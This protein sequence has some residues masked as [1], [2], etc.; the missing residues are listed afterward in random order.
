MYIT[1]G[2]RSLS[3]R[4]FK[5]FCTEYFFTFDCIHDSSG[6]PRALQMPFICERPHL[7][8]NERR[9]SDRADRQEMAVSY[10]LFIDPEGTRLPSVRQE[11]LSPLPVCFSA[12]IAE[13]MMVLVPG[14]PVYLKIY[15]GAAA[16]GLFNCA[17]L[18]PLLGDEYS[19]KADTVIKA[20]SAAIVIL[21][22]SE[23]KS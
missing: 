3:I 10:G 9:S 7:R 18:M 17:A 5:Y 6:S 1:T 12:G 22:F 23:Q 14:M 20:L 2:S 4:F 13:H 16:H 19:K 11:K 8:E 15:D 21:G